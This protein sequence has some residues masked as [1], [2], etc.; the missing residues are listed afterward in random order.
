MKSET[1]PY[2]GVQRVDVEYKPKENY[3]DRFEF[4]FKTQAGIEVTK[5]MEFL[6]G[7]ISSD[8]RFFNPGSLRSTVMAKGEVLGKTSIWNSADS[9]GRQLKHV[10]LVYAVDR[11]VDVDK[12]QILLA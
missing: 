1:D 9:L 7:Y 8:D 5:K 11:L 6:R 12:M 4:R 2:T 3:I 10:P